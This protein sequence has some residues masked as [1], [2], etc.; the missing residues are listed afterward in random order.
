MCESSWVTLSSLRYTFES[1]G[2]QTRFPLSVVQVEETAVVYLTTLSPFNPK[3]LLFPRGCAFWKECAVQICAQKIWEMDAWC[4]DHGKKWGMWE[5]AL[6]V[7][8]ELWSWTGLL[9]MGVG[10][11]WFHTNSLWMQVIPTLA[12]FIQVLPSSSPHPTPSQW[13]QGWILTSAHVSRFRS[14][15]LRQEW[16]VRHP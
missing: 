15:S 7:L 11:L 16:H 3:Y 5:W 8:W 12:F 14:V 2:L 10:S 9:V 13:N 6:A 4:W 1:W